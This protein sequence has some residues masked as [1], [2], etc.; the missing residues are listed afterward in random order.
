MYYKMVQVLQIRATITNWGK[1]NEVDDPLNDLNENLKK[2]Q[3]KDPSLV[4]ENMT[5]QDEAEADDKVLHCSITSAPFPFLTEELILEKLSAA[6]TDQL[7]S[8][9]DTFFSL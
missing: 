4:P 1:T 8:V 9:Y 2:M 6:N 7:S 3:T 5:V